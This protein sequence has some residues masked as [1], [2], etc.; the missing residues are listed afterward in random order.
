MEGDFIMSSN[1]SLMLTDYIAIIG[2]KVSQVYGRGKYMSGWKC[3][4]GLPLDNPSSLPYTFHTGDYFIVASTN[5]GV[6]D[7]YVHSITINEITVG[8]EYNLSFTFNSN[9]SS[10]Y[11]YNA[12]VEKLT[13]MGHV[14]ISNPLSASGSTGT[15]QII[16]G[17]FVNSGT[18]LAFIT[19][20]A[21]TTPIDI[22]SSTI[23]ISD[24]I[25]TVY[26]NNYKPNGNTYDGTP[27]TTLE[28]NPVETNDT[29]VFDGSHWGLI[30]NYK[31]Y[32]TELNLTSEN[33]PQTKVVKVA[34]D[35]CESDIGNVANNL[36]A[37]A[38]TRAA[39]DTA[40][41]TVLAGLQTNKVQKTSNASKV[42]ATD[43]NG[44]QTTLDYST[45]ANSNSIP[46]R[47]TG[48][49]VSVGTPTDQTH[50]TP[51]SYVDGAITTH[52]S[53]NDSHADMRSTLN[54]INS[55]IMSGTDRTNQLTNK[56]FVNSSIQTATATFQGTHDVVSDLHL[57]DQATNAEVAA[58]LPSVILTPSQNDY[59]FVSF[60]WTPTDEMK[61]RLSCNH[62]K[63]L[64][65]TNSDNIIYKRFKY[66]SVNS[67]W[68]FEYQLNNTIFTA[69]QFAAIDS[70]A[71]S[72]KIA[73][74]ATNTTAITGKQNSLTAGSHMSLNNDIINTNYNS[75][76]L[77]F[78]L[79]DDTTQTI[80]FATE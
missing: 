28:T 69:A 44:E 38:T 6:V 50:A 55:E 40:H 72:T 54:T 30:R 10:S 23:D 4:T 5:N 11:N 65:D 19:Q 20:D 70:G 12:I 13:D 24:S 37:E 43:T 79:E 80:T 29:Y 57:T 62:F 71:D 42:Y 41:D 39:A 48:G 33:A 34:I 16:T 74:I 22:N 47:S 61:E 51:K 21:P 73:Q 56:N 75:T 60:R 52:N 76:S 53:A 59:C 25:A 27:S 3:D 35:E 2:K 17:V 67:L 31:Y 77:V 14:D 68:Q 78:T 36:S 45:N 63:K 8:S 18:N 26:A 32:D 9:S 1:N 58:A 64:V 15:S 49:V 46:F 66:D 7:H